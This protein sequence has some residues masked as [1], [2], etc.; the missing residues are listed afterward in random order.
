LAALAFVGIAVAAPKPVG[1]WVLA[2]VNGEAA[3]SSA[4]LPVLNFTSP[5]GGY[6]NCP[7]TGGAFTLRQD[8]RVEFLNKQELRLTSCEPAGCLGMHKAA[9]EAY[10]CDE[11]FGGGT[12]HIE[13][14][15]IVI[16]SPSGTTHQFVRP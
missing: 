16:R 7:M 3:V 13:K 14:D 6:F 12:L 11:L 4:Y 15:R 9:Q 8:S 1:K 5:D 10:R 2:K